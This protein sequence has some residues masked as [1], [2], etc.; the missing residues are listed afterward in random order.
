MT[1]PPSRRELEN[2]VDALRSTGPATHAMTS[3]DR[4]DE[5]ESTARSVLAREGLLDREPATLTNKQ[6]RLALSNMGSD[7]AAAVRQA[8]LGA[9]S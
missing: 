6:I 7:L 2:R 1:G 3:I 9:H 8:D 4:T 5:L